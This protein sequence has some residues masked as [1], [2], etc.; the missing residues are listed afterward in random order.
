M[1]KDTYPHT[2]DCI[3]RLGMWVCFGQSSGVIPNFELQDLAKRGS[4]FATRPSLFSY[5]ATREELQHDANALFELMKQGIVRV[6]INQSFPLSE[7][8]EVHRMLEARETTG[9]TVLIP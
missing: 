5:V 2:L 7:A 4:L 9:S 8:T 1:G 3:K 6:Q